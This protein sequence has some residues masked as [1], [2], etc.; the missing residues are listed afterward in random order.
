MTARRV[1][2]VPRVRRLR[3]EPAPGARRTLGRSAR[4]VAPP[5]PFVLEPVDE[6]AAR[7]AVGVTLRRAI[8]V[9]DGR[10]PAEHLDGHLVPGLPGY[11]AA[12]VARRRSEGPSR[13]LRL[14]VFLPHADAAEVA[15]VCRVDGR[16]RALAARFERREAAW[17]CTV[18][19][20]L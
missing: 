9:L 4:A 14:R 11:W 13:V 5:E 10:R 19:R 2:S 12:E 20:L 16:V 15:A 18:L 17:M 8:E 7:Q 6:S 3:Y 1:L